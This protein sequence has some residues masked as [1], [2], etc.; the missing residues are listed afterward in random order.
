MAK[1]AVTRPDGLLELDPAHNAAGWFIL[2][3]VGLASALAL[4]AFNR[5]LERHPEPAGVQSA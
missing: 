3:G 2:M 1:N 4:W 5:W